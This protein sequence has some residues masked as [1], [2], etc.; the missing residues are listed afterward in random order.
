MDRRTFLR[1]GATG[2]GGMVLGFSLLGCKG[3]GESADPAAASAKP[4]EA[5]ARDLGA[6]EPPAAGAGADLNAWIRI[7]ADNKVT[8]FIPEA[9]MGQGI[10]TAVA[11]IIADELDVPW[12]GITVLHA[13]VN[14]E[15][16]GRQSTGGSTSIRRGFATMRKVA[17]SARKMLV[18][19]AAAEWKVP[20]STCVARSGEVTAGENRKATYGQL[21][22]AAAKL[23][24]PEAPAL[25]KPDQLRYIGKAT[26]RIDVPSKVDGSAVFGIDVRLPGMQVASVEHC[27]IFGGKLAKVDDTAARAVPGVVDVVAIPTGVAVVADH[28]WAAKK[29]REALAVTWDDGGFGSLSSASITE[30]CEKAAAGGAVARKDGNAAATIA[31]AANKVEAVYEVPYLAHTAMEPLNCTAHVTADGCEVW[32]PSQSPSRVAKKAAEITGLSP[33]KI[34]VHTTM[35][36]G[37]FGRR[38]QTDFV[39]DAVHVAVKTGK[40]VKVVWSRE[41]DVRGGWYRPAAYNVMSGAVDTDGTVLAWSHRIASPSIVRVAFGGLRNG[42]DPAGVEGAA[43]LPYAVRHMEVTY[44]DVE[45]PIPVWWWRSV[46]SSQ[47]AFVTECFFDELCAAAK[48][49]PF[50][51]RRSL[52]ARKPRHRAALELAAKHA[53][54]GDKPPAGRARGIAVH[55]SFGSYVAQVAEVSITG[56][57]PRV[58]RVVCAIDC[59]QVVNPD[60]VAAQMESGIAY[61]L[62]AVLHGAITIE[63][64][65]ARQSNF[66]DY[67]STRMSEMPAVETHI[68]PSDEPHGGVGEPGLPPLAPAV[69][70]ALFAL[71]GKPVRRLPVKLA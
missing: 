16:F 59:G 46:G 22:A 62:S 57:K 24:A 70:N 27:P 65:R 13:P 60:T 23:P 39:A 48:A 8:L 30:M 26:P 67:P 19:A 18:A 58:H 20:A 25:K 43:N 33:D 68:V 35:L 64:G 17:A 9:E 10:L 15:A 54:W 66:H 44:A 56:G 51:M 14:A 1:V 21:A 40:P 2:T 38:S 12:E 4:L 61:G 42:L 32:V 71:T 69:C 37:G 55:E 7:D 41:D 36:G 31:R 49:D 45:L 5:P 6:N 3:S 34:A 52:L 53:G 29:G 50:E 47:N 63:G 11:M 28:Y